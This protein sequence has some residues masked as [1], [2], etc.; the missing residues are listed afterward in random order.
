[1]RL[2]LQTILIAI[3][4]CSASIFAQTGKIAGVVKDAKTGELLMG[5][6]VVVEDTKAGAATNMDG[7]YAILN[8]PPGTYTL[9]ASMIGYS[10]ATIKDVRV[11]I[12]Q[13]S[14]INISLSDQSFTTQEVVV[15]AQTPVVQKDVAASTINLNVK[16]FE[17]MPVVNVASVIGLQAGVQSG[18]VIRGGGASQTSFMLNGLSLKDSRDNSPFMSVSMTAIDEIQIQTGGFNA[19]YGD[20]RSGLINVVTKEGKTDKYNVSFLG[21]MRPAGKK[22]FG[23]GPSSPDSYWLRGYMDDAV[24]WTGT[25]NGA[26]SEFTQ[27]QYQA[28]EGWNSVAQKLLTSDPAHAL[29]PSA[30]Q[31]L[32][33]WQ[34]RKD[35]RVQDPDYNYDMSISGPVPVVG[36][37]L[38]NLRFLA[39]LTGTK[40]M[41]A[42][43]LYTDDSKNYTGQ[44]KLT[45]DI[46]Q[47]MKVS[48]DGL[49]AKS[50]GTTTERSGAPGIFTSTGNIAYA[51]SNQLASADSRIY[52]TDY[53]EP[54]D[55]ERYMV[56]G[57]F[58]HVLSASTFYEAQASVF[59]TKY[60]TNPGRARDLSQ[61]YEIVPG[62]YTDEAPYGYYPYTSFGIGSGLRMGVGMSNGRDTTTFTKFATKFDFTSQLDKYNNIKTGF[63]FTY[64][65]NN[66]RYGQYDEVLPSSNTWYH[67]HTFPITAAVYAQDKIE[68]EGMIVNLGLRLDYSNPNTDWY[69]YDTYDPAF[70]NVNSG[71]MNQMLQKTHVDAQLNLSPRLAV[72]FPITETSKLFFNYGHFRQLPDPVNLYSIRRSTYDQNRL[73]AIANPDMPLQKTVAYELGYEQG[74]FDE[75]L[76]RVAGYYKD[77]TNQ[78]RT[79]TYQTSDGTVSYTTTQ[80]DNYGDYRGFE[81]T[82][83]KNRG[84][85]IT[86]FVN[87]TYGVSSS[88]NFNYSTYN[89]SASRQREFIR[90]TLEN[91]Q[92]KPI[93]IPYARANFDLFTPESD[94]GP[95]L[96]GVEILADWRLNLNASW[97]NGRYISWYGGG[98]TIQ[99]IQYNVQWQDTW[100]CDM[101]I[102][103]NFNFGPVRLELFA[104]ILNAFNFKQVVYSPDLGMAYGVVDANDWFDYM[105]SLHMQSDWVP[106]GKFGYM[107]VPGDDKPGAYRRAGADYTPMFAAKTLEELTSPSKSA[108]YWIKSTG[109]YMQNSGNGWAEV[110]QARI[111]KI[112]DDKS[113]IDMPNQD[114]LSFTDPRNIY[115]G[116]RFTVNF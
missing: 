96:G 3:L 9:K 115:W 15:V 48:F 97:N 99:G 49:Y 34:H 113:Y 2:V 69:V 82:V 17:N 19:E 98:G 41:L 23:N 32:F 16:Q 20:I 110:D 67:W 70:T 18:T 6:N 112:L 52:S 101:R 83:T 107:N 95:K 12:N 53:W 64:T 66:V 73:S 28:F 11:N 92:T 33:L 84:N 71:K 8:I 10:A 65:D 109:K 63:E 7:Y 85:W 4:L 40:Q 104:D 25:N 45:S 31:K 114:Y 87:Y 21:R 57:R 14:D 106:D 30:L 77:V 78:P 13:T 76:V 46:A 74:F 103:K 36:S 37:Y 26:W 68:Y 38:G 44:V 1:M 51:M 50:E 29:S 111:Q 47:G 54:T 62:Y 5:V 75:Y 108:I 88:G 94:F 86:G 100:T 55:Q 35:T 43:P 105:K 59:T 90:T 116:L 91:D 61:I 42:I 56:G 22:Y 27:K 93:P 72:A 81:A 102:S 58:T 79:V 89:Q 39:S 60:N 80:P 24:C